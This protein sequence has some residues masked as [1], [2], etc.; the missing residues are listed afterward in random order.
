MKKITFIFVLIIA[1]FT[2]GHSFSQKVAI[3][4]YNGTSPDG[5][6]FVALEAIPAGTTIYFTEN[7]HLGGG[8]FNTGEGVWDWVA[9]AGG[10]VKGH[11]VVLQEDATNVMTPTCTSAPCGTSATH[12]IPISLASTAESVYA[13]ADTD[14]DPSNG[15]TEIYSVF[16]SDGALPGGESPTAF[17]PNAIVVDGLGTGTHAQYNVGLRAPGPTSKANLENPGNYTEAAGYLAL[18]NTAFANINLGGANPALTVA[19]SPGT[20]TE[21]GA[22][23]L[24]Y[25]FTL[26]SIASANVFVQYSL[27]GTADG[28]DYVASGSVTIPMGSTSA[29]LTVNP[30]V[31]SN[32]EPDETVIVTITAGSN[33]DVGNPSFATGTIINDDTMT[34]TPVVAVTGMNN[35]TSPTIEGFSFVALDNIMAGTEVFF[36]ENAFDKNLLKFGAG[37]GVVRWTAP[38]GGVPRGEVI[39]AVETTPDT[40]TASCNSGTCGSF[41]TIATNFSF[42]ATGEGFFAYS[43]SD[44]DPTNGVTQVHSVLFSGTT[45]TPGG[46]IPVIEN[47]GSVYSGAV[48]VDGFPASNPVLTE[49]TPALRSVTVDQANFQNIANWD[50]AAANATPS[51][52]PFTNI[53]IATGSALPAA[54]VTVTPASVAED[55]GTGM[56][57]TFMLDAPAAGDVTINFTV[58]GTAIAGLDY[59]QTGAN[60]FTGTNGSVVINNLA[61][62]ATVTITPV[63]DTQVETTETIILA[64]ASGTGYDGGTPSNATGSITN[65]DTSSSDPLIAITGLSHDTTDGFSF[66]AAKDIPA[67]T[68]VYFS[69]DEFD[70]SSLTF[71]S[72]E[73]VLQ[74]TSPGV[75]FPK[76]DVV[77]VTETGIDTFTLTCSGTGGVGCGTLVVINGNFSTAVDGETFYAYEDTDTDPTNGV[78]DIYAVLYTG[79]PSGPG[80]PIPAI[81]DPSGIYLNALVVDGFPA[82]N[83][84]R[85]EYDETKRNVPVTN[86]DFE[87][88]ANWVHAQPTP[89]LSTVPFTD[90]SIGNQPPTAIC[91]NITLPLDAM[92]N[93]T[94]TPDLVDNGSTDDGGTVFL[95]FETMSFPT[96]ISATSPTEDFGGGFLPYEASVFTVPTTGNYTFNMT[97]STGGNGVLII[98]D[99]TPIPNSGPFNAR[100][101]FFDLAGWDAAGALFTGTGVFSL[102]ANKT[103]YISIVENVGNFGTFNTTIDLAIKT[104]A[105]S[106]TYTCNNAGDVV[107]ETLY[108]FDREG[109]TSSCATTVTI[110]QDSTA[111]VAL[112]TSPTLLLDA[113]GNT[114]LTPA[115][116]DG[117]STD[118]CGTPFL[119][120][121]TTSFSGEVTGASPTDE[122]NVGAPFPYEASA[123]TVSTSGNYTFNMTGTTTGGGSFI[124]IWDDTPVP[125]S[126]DFNLRP[127]FFDFAVWNDAGTLTTG[128]GIFALVAGQTYYMTRA[129][130]NLG[131]GMFTTTADVAI[132]TTAANITYT[133]A[134]IG[135]FLVT[136][137]AFDA[138]GNTDSCVSTVTV[139]GNLTTYTGGAW[140]NGAPNLGSKAVIADLLTTGGTSIEACSCQ[141]DALLAVTDG[142]YLKVNGDITVS[143]TGT[144][145]VA[146]EGSVVQI[147][148]TASVNNGGT[149]QVTKQTPTIAAKS[150]M[151]MS[152]PVSAETREDVYAN[153][154]IVRKHITSNFVPNAAVA[155][156]DPG[157][158]NFADDNGNNWLTHTLLLNPAEGYMVFPQPDGTSAG[159]FTHVYETGTLNNGVYTKPL[160]FNTNQNDSPN[161]IGNPYPSAISADAFF[162]E[163]ANAA[164]DDLY[165][166]EHITPLSTGYPGYNL[167]NFSMGD[168]SLY[169]EMSGGVKAANDPGTSTI[170]TGIISSGQGFGLKA[171]SAGIT[172]TFNNS[173]RVNGPNDTYRAPSQVNRDRL[174]LNIY[175]DTY[176]LGSN[177]LISFTENTTDSYVNGQDVKRLATPVSFYS[178]LDSGEQLVINAL[179]PFDM[180]DAV[181]LSF[182][183]QVKETQNYRISIDNLDGV[184]MEASTVYLIDALTGTV[185]NLSEADYT[186]QS[187]EATY[188]KRFKVV[189]ENGALGI[190]DNAISHISLYPNPTEGQLNI[191]SPNAA[192]SS[193]TIFDLQ[194]RKVVSEVFTEN[195]NVQI[196]ISD[197]NSAMYFV[198]I[199]TDAGT[200]TKRL[201]KK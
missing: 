50:H 138:A 106:T 99:D 185:T 49:Y 31:D 80:G 97:S 135:N 55:N 118:D 143:P 165:F 113:M 12:A 62:S 133:C 27:S 54:S 123:F 188:S 89:A 66:V 95:A 13:Y 161:I 100:P 142:D 6:S 169:N 72:G 21:D 102:V 194:G 44:T 177:L 198:D 157:A 180:Q 75:T 93:A 23:N 94:L 139:D 182:K 145:T 149:I 196:D 87:N 1:L 33:Y 34:I 45:V 16:M 166:W 86:V 132:R 65:D 119:A 201:I 186:F 124:I 90:L 71:S 14:T 176:G 24:I 192:I 25:T 174:W 41:T 147:D 73:S 146:T 70:N 199:K 150:F 167:A 130:F 107:N 8:V 114:V 63:V 127:E 2:T 64:I 111:P 137:Y 46:N 154:Y 4:G 128:T 148:D 26:A 164:I 112:C 191:A 122:L 120:L 189:F 125:N 43:D 96:E 69:E 20:V 193:V 168:I 136:L 57:Y 3:I 81:E 18:S 117:G 153:S 88:I 175:N 59:L 195:N 53:I 10:I 155:T 68:V 144:L 78:A 184:N 29:T 47:P 82:T 178:E 172:A 39:V 152:S 173:M 85:T 40:F 98:W 11:V 5:I 42:A 61:N 190:E 51:I 179:A 187:G 105:A 140:D 103:Y 48:V 121:E 79:G 30:N 36:T 22:T 56:V 101:E 60:T 74:W 156:F 7:E 19:V 171:A 83:P 109:N 15:T 200:V 92:G 181:A 158:E 104:T 183:T 126:G 37:E 129:G 160:V 163:P 52:I 32:L 131:T 9:P 116:L 58:G 115:L 91:Q 110:D 76:G 197:L 170:P 141:I 84:A 35:A 162:A 134:D 159:Q 108:V 38:A 151:I 77:V 28:A 17:S 67:G